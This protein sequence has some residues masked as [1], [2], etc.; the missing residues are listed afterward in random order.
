M[1]LEQSLPFVHLPYTAE[2][3]CRLLV[4]DEI[5]IDHPPLEQEDVELRP[6]RGQP[7]PD[8]V[9]ESLALPIRSDGNAIETS[10]RLQEI[11]QVFND[12]ARDLVP[13]FTAMGV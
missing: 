8:P 4:G 9:F 5:P 12:A 1:L 10:A 2:R 6:R 11:R 7:V 13:Q 3:P